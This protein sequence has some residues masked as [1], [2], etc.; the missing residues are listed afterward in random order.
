MNRAILLDFLRNSTPASNLLALEPPRKSHVLTC[1]LFFSVSIAA[2]FFAGASYAGSLLSTAAI[3]LVTAQPGFAATIPEIVVTATRSPADL[4]QI[5]SSMTIIDEEEIERKNKPTIAELLRGVPGLSVANSGGPGQSTRVFMRG[6]NSNHVLVLMDGVRLNDPSDPNDAFDFANLMTDNI[7]RIEILRGAQSTLYGSQAIGGVINIISKQGSGAPR[8]NGFSEYG[9]YNSSR[10]GVGAQGEAQGLS[11]ALQVSNY[12]TN[13]ISSMAKRFGGQEKDGSNIYTF[14]GNVA[15]KLTDQLTAKLNLRYNRNNTQFDSPGSFTRPYDDSFPNNDTRQIQGRVAGEY[16]SLGGKW[17]Q[18]LGFS[19]L[20]LHRNQ[21]TELFDSSFNSYFGR[22]QYV[23][24]R[25]KADWVHHVKLIP[26]HA[27]TFGVE[28]WSDHYK[29]NTIP[30][31]ALGELNVDNRALF[32]D[33]QYTITPNLFVN[34]G[35]RSD[36]HQ[37]FGRQTTWKVAPGY[38]IGK[39]GTLLK[40]SYGTGFK[41]PSLF[42]LYDLTYGN[43]LLS[44]E[45]SK[46]YDAGFEQTLWG[47]KVTFGATI[48]RNDIRGLLDTVEVAPLIYKYVNIGRARTQGVESS[49]EFRPSADWRIAG[50]YTFTQADDRSTDKRLKRRPK[51]LVNVSTDWQYSQEGDVGVSL[52]HVGTSFDSNFS[53]SPA[54]T[55]PFTTLDLYTNYRINQTATLYG[56]IDNLLDKRYEEVY[57]YGEPGLSLF[58][59][60]KLSY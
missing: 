57:G 59:G 42:S 27:F 33:D 54:N 48:F 34:A 29:L 5:A 40:A 41:A 52:R 25:E 2:R 39:I 45:T 12:H 17:T 31:I 9:R 15:G 8:Y 10:A 46:S 1:T 51:H 28:A 20:T 14:S 60:V 50:T 3:I 19:Y 49:L 24:W 18:E 6:T 30:Q 11:Y 47:D 53:F 21:I 23:S 44:S 58:A 55:S 56:R 16:S 35:I 36:M 43:P 13:G 37:S 4:S 7:A 32:F 38:R 22:Q 26:D